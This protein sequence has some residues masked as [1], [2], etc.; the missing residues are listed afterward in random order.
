MVR[1]KFSRELIKLAV[2]RFG[3]EAHLAEA[4]GTTRE[5]LRAWMSGEEEA[6][7]GACQ[8]IADLLQERRKTEE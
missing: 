5:R 4:I 3:S 2:E 6:P 8:K 7:P 1:D